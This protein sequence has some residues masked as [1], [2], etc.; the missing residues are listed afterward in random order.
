MRKRDTR[1]ARGAFTLVEAV[2]AIAIVGIGVAAMMSATASGT[3]ANGDSRELATAMSLAQEIREW[4]ATLPFSDPDPGQE[5]NPPGPDGS[6]PQVF[7]DDL[8][9][10]MSVTYSPPR[11]GQGV[12]IGAMTDWSQTISLTWRNPANLSAAVTP[13]TSDVIRVQ[14]QI[15]HRGKVV[16]TTC[17][18]IGRRTAS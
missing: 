5:H 18:L 9:D 3:R 1:S 12:A 15:A 6:S 8:D 14:V 7:V 13:G 4:T 17:W 2:V 11:N 16:L 10:L